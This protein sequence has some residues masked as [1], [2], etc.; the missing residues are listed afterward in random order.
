MTNEHGMTRW[1]GRVALVTGASEG[2]GRAVASM[3][4]RSGMRVA[5]CARSVERLESLA[6]ELPDASL[7]VHRADL[8]DEAQIL[9]LFSE[10]RRSLGG[11]D[12]LVNNAGLGYDSS[13][14]SGKTEHW[15]EMLDV[16]VLALAIATR[17]ALADMRRTD[18]GHIVHMSSMA[19]HRVPAGSGV[20]AATKF[21]VRALTEALRQE[22]RAL[23]SRIRVS[24]V[25]PGTVETEF[26]ARASGSE[27]AARECYSRFEPLRPE[28]V[29]EAVRYLISAPPHAEVHDI[30]MRPTAQPV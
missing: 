19:G 26:A 7:F 25:S 29:A 16:N 27:E 22:L 13:L 5:I 24:S 3:L 28:D 17:E 14:L 8:R 20:Y 21:A 23:G 11:V 6:R 9:G 4:A 1:T 10:I 18:Q 2:I 12:L 15:R 30:L